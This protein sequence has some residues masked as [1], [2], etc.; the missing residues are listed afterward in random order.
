MT[1]SQLFE[2]VAGDGDC[3]GDVE[4]SHEYVHSAG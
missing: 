1:T 4:W 3:R 2:G